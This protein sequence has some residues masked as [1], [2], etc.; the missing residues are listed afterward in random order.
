MSAAFGS[1]IRL[2]SLRRLQACRGLWSE[3]GL[4]ARMTVGRVPFQKANGSESDDEVHT[5]ASVAIEL[6][7]STAL[8]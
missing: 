1:H 2:V 7:E 6:T 4:P 3:A 5:R 8:T